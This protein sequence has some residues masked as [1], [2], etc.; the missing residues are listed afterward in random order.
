MAR[1]DLAGVLLDLGGVVYAGDRPLPGAIEAIA[2]LKA[3]GLPLRFVTNTTRR[4]R[5]VLLALLQRL[6]IPARAEELFMPAVAARQIL[7][8]KRLTPQLLVHP[9]LEED[10]AGLPP[11]QQTA[12][13][14]GDAAEG[15]TF[16]AMNRAFR[17]LMGGAVFLAL[18]RN[19]C[20]QDAD[21]ELSIDAGAFV[22]ALQFATR[23][24]A[25]VLGKPSAAFFRSA[26]ES[27]GCTPDRAVMIGDDAENDVAGALAAG[28]HGILVRTGKYRPGDETSLRPAPDAVLPDLPAA[29]AWILDRATSVAS[30]G[31]DG[32]A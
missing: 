17:A 6:G 2:R 11:G 12:V 16:Q 19:R 25:T 5:R 29:A 8:A 15:F 18:A 13:V 24:Q 23:R 1:P 9:A 20:F 28:L 26:V 31:S 27:L 14:V 4:P 30:R 3:A 7:E 21:G 32:P 22:E 10:F